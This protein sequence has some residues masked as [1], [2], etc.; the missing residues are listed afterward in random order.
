MPRHSTLIPMSGP[1]EGRG[2]VPGTTA[3]I[4]S[5][6]DTA[7]AHVFHFDELLDAVLGAF[8]AQARL[9]HAPERRHLGRDESGVHAHHSVLER[10]RDAPDAAD[11]AAVEIRRETELGAVRKLDHLG[12]VIEAD[13]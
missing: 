10:F 11:V 2:E 13:Q 9:L 12:V 7:E 5:R 8:T 4:S 1:D 6:I 3:M